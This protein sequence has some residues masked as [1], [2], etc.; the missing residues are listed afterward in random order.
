MD[1][2][3]FR[4][5]TLK[6][7]ELESEIEEIN[8]SIEK[9]KDIVIQRK[10]HVRMKVGADQIGNYPEIDTCIKSDEAVQKCKSAPT[11]LKF[12]SSKR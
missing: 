8:E 7:E 12:V 3:F 6:S 2:T 9:M 5:R 1:L 4:Q 10:K 11:I